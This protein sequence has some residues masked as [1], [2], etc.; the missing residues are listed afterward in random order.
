MKIKFMIFTLLLLG[1]T[2]AQPGEISHFEFNQASNTVLLTWENSS[3]AFY[4]MQ[5]STNLMSGLWG[6]EGGG[7]NVLG[8]NPTNSYILPADDHPHA[9]FRLITRKNSSYYSSSDVIALRANTN[10]LASEWPHGYPGDQ[11]FV[12]DQNTSL[13]NVYGY[14]AQHAWLGST[15]ITNNQSFFY[16]PAKVEIPH[17]FSS[18][19][20]AKD[21]RLT[22]PGDL[23]VTGNV[24]IEWSAFD[25]HGTPSNPVPDIPVID[26]TIRNSDYVIVTN[27]HLDAP[28]GSSV[29]WESNGNPDGYYL[30][31]LQYLETIEKQVY[32]YSQ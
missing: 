19:A 29:I 23:P 20:Y 25:S 8:I 31:D 2:Y 26:V 32:L 14:S 18:Y 10:L 16:L 13:Y 1:T 17:E 22:S 30:I 5:S 15:D 27:W 11:L 28:V 24:L 21:W 6:Q 3:N 7:T 12:W 9:F 4:E